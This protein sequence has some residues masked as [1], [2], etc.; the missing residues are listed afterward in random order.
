L[1]ELLDLSGPEPTLELLPDV[2]ADIE[3]LPAR[4]RAKQRAEQVLATVGED[5][6]RAGGFGLGAS[7]ARFP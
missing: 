1:K 5:L 4:Q 3:G 6:F 2:R 7:L